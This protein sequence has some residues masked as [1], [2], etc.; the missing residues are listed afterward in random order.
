MYKRICSYTVAVVCWCSANQYVEAQDSIYFTAYLDQQTVDR[1][2]S[3]LYWDYFSVDEPV[4]GSYELDS[5]QG[6]GKKGGGQNVQF[7][8]GFPL[9][10]WVSGTGRLDE[11]GTRIDVKKSTLVDFDLFY[12]VS[13]SYS[14]D[15]TLQ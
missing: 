10:V 14:L 8:F 11:T 3:Y 13:G 2:N 9:D 4:W 6:K 15:L 1:L 5:S 12:R 7:Y